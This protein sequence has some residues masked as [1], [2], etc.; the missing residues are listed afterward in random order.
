M[1]L[2]LKALRYMRDSS[3]HYSRDIENRVAQEGQS[4]ELRET[5]M[6][7]KRRWAWACERIGMQMGQG[8]GR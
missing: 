6:R 2:T 7:A 5:F 1:K 4:S 8:R 3:F